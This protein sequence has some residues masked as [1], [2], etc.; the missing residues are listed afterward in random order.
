MPLLSIVVPS[1]NEDAALPIFHDEVARVVLSMPNVEIEFIFVDDGS[2]D[3]TLAVIRSL[4]A[5]DLRV[6]YV[7]FSRNF[8]K[9]AA[10]LAGLQHARGDH[11]VIMDA[12]LQDP[13]ALLPEMVSAV[14]SG[15][16]DCVATRRT[17]RSGESRIRSFFARAFYRLFNAMSGTE[18]VSGARDYRLMSRKMVDAVLEL[19][20]VN[21]FSKGLMAWVGFRTKWLEF[22]NVERSAGATSWSFFGL[23]R[24]SLEGI[25]DF[26]TAP[27]A[28]ASG[29]GFLFCFASFV[30]IAI[31]IVRKLV[32]NNAIVGWASLACIVLFAA[33]MQFFTIGILGQYL[34]R[35]YMETKHRPVY[36]VRETEE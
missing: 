16:W 17:T 18:I 19:S 24:Y 9:E 21:R 26:S 15:E 5:A 29:L 30:W 35:T 34:A 4:R 11:V 14:A 10:L 2:S 6:R 22:E 12:D 27:L 28:M 20:E 8:G 7:S 13:P 32:F 33:G 31:I 36:I 25:T 1:Y 3:D 23:V